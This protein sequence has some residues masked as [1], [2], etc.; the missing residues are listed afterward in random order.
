VKVVEATAVVAED[1]TDFG[2]VAE[3]S[4]SAAKPATCFVAKIALVVAAPLVV[5]QP[6]DLGSVVIVA[7]VVGIAAS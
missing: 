7:E 4:A 3:A 2:S 1:L 6:L 5:H